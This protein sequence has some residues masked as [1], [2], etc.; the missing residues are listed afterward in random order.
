MASSPALIQQQTFLDMFG[1]ELK[2]AMESAAEPIIK[3][4]IADMEYKMRE[5]MAANLIAT[6][7]TSLCV[8][9]FGN[10]VQIIIKGP[11]DNS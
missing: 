3:K 7:K 11:A 8:N 1:K 9:T 5:R 2:A 4:A 10:E 6:I